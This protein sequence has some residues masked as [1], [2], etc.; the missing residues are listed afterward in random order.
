VP[1]ALKAVTLVDI[2]PAMVQAWRAE[3]S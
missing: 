2:D 1:H 3:L